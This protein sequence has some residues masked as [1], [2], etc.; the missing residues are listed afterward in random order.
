MFESTEYTAW[1]RNFAPTVNIF[2]KS[3][4]Y[5]SSFNG[6]LEDW[7]LL[8]KKIVQFLVFRLFISLSILERQQCRNK[9]VNGAVCYQRKQ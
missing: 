6:Y 5:N 2:A 4:F 1:S 3:T 9:L 7:V 8:V